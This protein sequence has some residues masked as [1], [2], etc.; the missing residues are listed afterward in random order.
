[1]SSSAATVTGR[2]H[3]E[4]EDALFR[5]DE[6]RLYVV[7]DGLGGHPGGATASHLL[8][9]G[10]ASAFTPSPTR[11]RE[12][13]KR[14]LLAAIDAAAKQLAAEGREDPSHAE[15]ATTLTLL[16]LSDEDSFVFH[17][18]DSRAYRVREKRLAQLTR[19]HSLAFALFEAG[20]IS[21]EEVAAHPAQRVLTRS[22]GAAR[23]S[24]RTDVTSER[25]APGDSFILCSDGLVKALGDDEILSIALAR[26]V[27]ERARALVDAAVAA[28]EED[29]IT[30]VAVEITSRSP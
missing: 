15:M 11:D 3:D 17:V 21:R 23:R 30:A 7:C 19:D 13:T 20:V 10:I 9:G 28:G 25:W 22:I 2:I 4:N 18:G 5:D 14:R 8:A 6:R 1:M 29:D 16:H 26:S 12:D 24:A 27:G